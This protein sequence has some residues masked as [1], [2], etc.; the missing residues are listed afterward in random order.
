MPIRIV[1]PAAERAELLVAAL[2][3]FSATVAG[4]DDT[5]E[6][7]VVVDA[8]SSARLVD[9]FNAVG[10][11]VADG[12]DETCQ[13]FFGDSPYTLFAVDGKPNDPTQFLLQRTIQLQTALDTRV[14][15]EQAKGVLAERFALSPDDAF[16]LLRGA[17]RSSGRRI[18]DLAR[19]V[20]ETKETPPEIRRHLDRT[21][22]GL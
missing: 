3:G 10:Q 11:W 9:L 4:E 1:C 18:H 15:I 14:V 16:T 17:A 13:V 21:R 22:S 8:E 19:E 6:V 2:E 7:H 20:V 5:R 12:K